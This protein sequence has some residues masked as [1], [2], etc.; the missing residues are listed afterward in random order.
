MQAQRKSLGV[1][2]TYLCMYLYLLNKL[3]WIRSNLTWIFRQKSAQILVANGLIAI[4]KPPSCTDAGRM[5]TK[6][7][8]MCN[9]KSSIDSISLIFKWYSFDLSSRAAP[10]NLPNNQVSKSWFRCMF[11]PDPISKVTPWSNIYVFTTEACFL[12]RHQKSEIHQTSQHSF[13]T[14]VM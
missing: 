10:A 7:I 14:V 3:F 2:Y 6:D 11:R 13:S 8:H 12:N 5:K 9:Y 1:S 4:K